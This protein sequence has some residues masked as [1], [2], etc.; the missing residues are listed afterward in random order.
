M[1]PCHF[2]TSYDLIQAPF[3]IFFKYALRASE[4]FSIKQITEKECYSAGE[5]KGKPLQL[6][7]KI[8]CADKSPSILSLALPTLSR[9]PSILQELKCYLK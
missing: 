6:F 7:H 5:S 2:S 3:V 8:K 9:I 1:A 4:D